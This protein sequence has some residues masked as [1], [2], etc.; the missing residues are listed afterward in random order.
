[1]GG[2]GATAE[3]VIRA[4]GLGNTLLNRYFGALVQ[5]RG[6]F[7]TALKA[8]PLD[9]PQKARMTWVMLERVATVRQEIWQGFKRL[10][11]DAL[12]PFYQFLRLRF[13]SHARN[14][15]QDYRRVAKALRANVAPAKSGEKRG[16]ILLVALEGMNHFVVVMWGVLTWGLRAYGYETLAVTLRAERRNN[17]L[18]RLFRVQLTALEDCTNS[19]T[20][21]RDAEAIATKLSALDTLPAVLAFHHDDLVPH[22]R[23]R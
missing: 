11:K 7:R 10:I 2:S 22:R 1:L 15:F 20:D 23:I 4:L 16:R 14:A 12:R 18:L 19:E 3:G 17:R 5:T 21:R 6:L 13:G 9:L 8:G